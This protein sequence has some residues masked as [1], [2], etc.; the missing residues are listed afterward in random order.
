M[1]EIFV[2]GDARRVAPGTT[3]AE[4]V[5]ILGLQPR[6]VAVER[7]EPL[8]PRGDH[9]ECRLESADRIEIVTLVGGG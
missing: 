8:V 7:N 2:N 9:A 1:I 6:F 4:L 5:A 3:L